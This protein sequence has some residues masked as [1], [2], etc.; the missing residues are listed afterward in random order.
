[1]TAD[2]EQRRK[3]DREYRRRRRLQDPEYAE[4]ERQRNREYRLRRRQDPVKVEQDRRRAREWHRKRAAELGMST[5]KDYL[6]RKVKAGEMTGAEVAL[7]QRRRALRKNHKMTLEQYDEIL[8][9]QN[10]RCAICDRT[11]EESGKQYLDVDH[12]HESGETRGLLCRTCNTALGKLSTPEL[13]LAAAHYLSRRRL[14]LV[15]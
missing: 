14:R 4:A 7:L 12:D 1:M 13:L 11:A 10:G 6:D 8:D 3:Y 2:K 15:S 9:I 5:S